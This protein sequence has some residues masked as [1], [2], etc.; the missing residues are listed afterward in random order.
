MELSIEDWCVKLGLDAYE[1]FENG[2]INVNCN[3][4]FSSTKLDRIPIQF[5]IVNGFL[6]CHNIQLKSLKGCPSEVRDSF[7]CAINQ[8]IS[9]EGGPMKVGRVFSC[10]SNK[11]TSLIGGPTHVG[12]DYICENN[13]LISLEGIP[14]KINGSFNCE[15]NPVYREYVKYSSHNQYNRAIKLRELLSESV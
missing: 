9:L 7:T 2:I 1:I 13:Q 10:H 8:L 6:N 14:N 11:L 4:N 15:H 3:V 12:M 5:G